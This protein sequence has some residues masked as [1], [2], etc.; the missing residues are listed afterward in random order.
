MVQGAER[1]LVVARVRDEKALRE[2]LRKGLGP[3][4]NSE[5]VGEFEIL[6]SGDKRTATSFIGNYLLM[7]SPS[8]VKECLQ[9]R[10]GRNAAAKDELRKRISHFVPLSNSANIITYTNDAERVESLLSAISL[11]QGNGRVVGPAQMLAA[12]P[13]SATETSL[14]DLGLDRRTR[15]SFGLFT[16]IAALLFPN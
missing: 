7:G 4:Q 13:Y 2:L 16:T 12:V 5:R 9:N 1:S 15:S 11:A 10:L 8:D 6:E 3:S 14:D